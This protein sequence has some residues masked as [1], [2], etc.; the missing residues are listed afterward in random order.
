MKS[1]VALTAI[2]LIFLLTACSSRRPES[3]YPTL[4]DADK[5]G[6][7]TRGWLPDSMPQSF[8]NIHEV[9]EISPSK[10][11]C[12]FEFALS[13]S[14]LLRKKLKS[15][16]TPP[17]SVRRVANPGVAWWP[18]FLEGHLDIEKIRN[19]GFELYIAERQT[20][21]VTTDISLF[22]IDWSKGRGFFY[23]TVE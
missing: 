19:Q 17:Q 20:T 2:G 1:P 14:Q 8:R 13:D 6:A 23:S 12:T 15:V 18:A 21:S 4:I 22:A 5:N 11:W 3:F 7:I 9:H 10:E 16:N